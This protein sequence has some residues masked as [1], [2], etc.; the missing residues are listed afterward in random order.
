MSYWHDTISTIKLDRWPSSPP[1][2]QN[3]TFGNRFCDKLKQWFPI[4]EGATEVSQNYHT[5]T[6]PPKITHVFEFNKFT[7]WEWPTPADYVPQILVTYEANDILQMPAISLPRFLKVCW[8]WWDL[9]LTVYL[10]YDPILGL[11][12]F[13]VAICSMAKSIVETNLFD[14][15][16]DWWFPYGV[17]YTWI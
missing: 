7:W 16:E 1:L 12:L 4:F 11:I 8:F 2:Y 10:K 3:Q 6:L 17:P 9:C 5:H 15:S 13:P 14:S